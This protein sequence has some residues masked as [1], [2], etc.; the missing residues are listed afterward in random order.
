MRFCLDHWTQLRE[1]V[2]R[3]GLGE[4]VASS[5]E[6]VALRM[7]GEG[8]DP[9]MGAHMAIIGALAN[10]ANGGIIAVMQLEGCPVCEADAAHQATCQDQPC[11]TSYARWFD[12]AVGDQRRIALE[13]GLVQ[14]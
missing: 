6:E 10:M 13:R 9:L 11:T 2:D 4:F 7:R 8:F 12:G 14:P 5:G 1:A 3:A